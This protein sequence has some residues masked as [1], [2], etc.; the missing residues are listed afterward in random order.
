[1]LDLTMLAS[2]P[3]V[4]GTFMTGGKAC[5][6][7]AFCTDRPKSR[8]TALGV[9]QALKLQASSNIAGMYLKTVCG[10]VIA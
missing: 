8:S 1:M 2:V 7:W 3:G 9:L 5:A 10:N 6:L 4:T